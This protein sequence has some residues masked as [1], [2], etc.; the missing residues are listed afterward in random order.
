MLTQC[1]ERRRRPRRD[2]S[3]SVRVRAEQW[4]DFDNGVLLDLSEYGIRFFTV[5][6]LDLGARVEIDLDVG[7]DRTVAQGFS[8]QIVRVMRGSAGGFTY[9][10]RLA[11]PGLAR[12]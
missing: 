10:C 6:S 4:P 8:G 3:A 9:A 1:L 12:L 2:L 5:R 7:D 11:E